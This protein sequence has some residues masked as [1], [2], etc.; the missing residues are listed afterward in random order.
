MCHG[1]RSL[2]K[3]IALRCSLVRG[4]GRLGLGISILP[5]L[6][7]FQATIPGHTASSCSGKEPLCSPDVGL[8]GFSHASHPR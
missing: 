8:C 5:A 1:L 6:L 2:W 7:G 4:A 3:A